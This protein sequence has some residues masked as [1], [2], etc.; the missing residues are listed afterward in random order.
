[1]RKTFTS[2]LF[3][4]YIVGLKAEAR[5]H[6]RGISA[7]PMENDNGMTRAQEVGTAML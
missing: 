3:A 7:K 2:G 5:D 1:M 6:K 4:E